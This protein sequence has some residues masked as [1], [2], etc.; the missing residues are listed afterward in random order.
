MTDRNTK[1]AGAHGLKAYALALGVSGAAMM[2]AAGPVMAQAPEAS[3]RATRDFDIAAQP[4]ATAIAAYGRQAGL[5]VTAQSDVTAGV[6]AQ[7][8]RGQF[9]TTD[10]LSR[11]LEGTGVTWRI[12]GGVVVLSRAPRGDGALRLGAVRVEGDGPDGGQGAGGPYGLPPA[13][14]GGQVARGGQLGL[15]GNVDV[16]DTPFNVT[17]YTSE[18]IENQNSQTLMDV[19]DNDPS[20]RASAPRDGDSSTVIIRGFAV[21]SREI[22]VN[23]MFGPSDTRGQMIESVERVEVH[24]GPSAMLNGVSPWGSSQGGS[25]NYVLKRAGDDPLTRLTATYASESQVGGHVDIGRRFGANKAFGVRVNGVYREG[26]TDVDHTHNRSAAIAVALDY[27][28]EKLRLFLDLNHQDRLLKGGWS[29]TRIGSSVVVPKAPDARINSKQAWEFWD[30]QNDYAIARAEYDIAPGW[31][32]GGAYGRS[33]SDELYLLTIDSISNINGNKSGTPYWIPARSKN[34]SGE[35]SLKGGFTTGP[36]VHQVSAIW[37]K[38][39]SQRGQLNWSVPGYGNNSL[40]SNIYAPTYFPAPDTSTLNTDGLKMTSRIDYA[41][42]AVA[43]IMRFWGDKAIVMVGARQQTTGTKTYNYTTELLASRYR[44]DRISPSVGVVLKPVGEHLSFYGSYI[45]SLN[46]GQ[47]VSTYYANAGDIFQPYVTDQYEAGVKYDRGTFTVT[48]NWF[49]V[50]VPSFTEIA[51]TTVGGRP[52]LSLDGDERHRGVEVNVF[53]QLTPNL[54]LLGGIMALDAEMVRT[55]GGLN[56]GKRARGAPKLNVNLGAE[57]DVKAVP[58]LTVTGRVVHTTREMLDLTQTRARSIPT[59]TRVDA[60]VRYAFDIEGRPA[61]LSV[62]ADNLLD[63]SYWAAASRGVLTM[64]AP[65][66]VRA[67]LA[68]DF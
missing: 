34:A 32:V 16:M 17:R 52:S 46:Q 66:S 6:Q 1:Q 48:A 33:T 53:G 43:D 28:T 8:V 45:E 63:K 54:R 41:G 15:L 2:L 56:D 67:S 11:L 55:E 68:V 59:W 36:V 58:G 49:T 51:A 44:R 31:T 30:G 47:M 57:W 9:S 65:R 40:P 42:L 18:L 38:N 24:K 39:I 25:V 20:V 21:Q 62:T 61:K 37:T 12:D 5:Q 23:G 60:G 19:L 14:A 7:A 3:R 29:S 10:A 64:G 50:S 4:L 13:Y 27:R 26:S 35:L 22:L